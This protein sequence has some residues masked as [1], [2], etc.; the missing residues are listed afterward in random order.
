MIPDILRRLY[1]HARNRLF[2]GGEGATKI[3][4]IIHQVWPGDDPIPK[5]LLA[6]AA[7]WRRHHPNWQYILWD[8]K[9]IPELD[10]WKVFD[11]FSGISSRSNA[12]RLEAVHRHGGIYADLDFE[13]QKNL[14]DLIAPYEA[15]TGWER[16]E[17]NLVGNAF[18]GAVPRHPWLTFQL[19]QLP[20]LYRTPPP[21]GPSLMTKA[22]PLFPDVKIF[23]ERYFYPYW[24][25]QFD[26]RT[27]PFPEAYAIHRWCWCW[28]GENSRRK[29]FEAA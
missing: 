2:R 16:L 24:Y 20:S 26:R 6:Y 19:E 1:G 10:C 23:E 29:H 5:K 22:C 14:T 27:E 8:L 15:F 12:V 11:Q 3:P 28:G 17:L 4:K 13:C 25:N 18:F 9:N 7:S 21:W